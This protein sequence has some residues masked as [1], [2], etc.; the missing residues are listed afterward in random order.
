MLLRHW[1]KQNSNCIYEEKNFNKGRT[2]YETNFDLTRPPVPRDKRPRP[3]IYGKTNL[4]KETQKI[5]HR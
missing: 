1:K 4:I 3:R 2:Y 5:S